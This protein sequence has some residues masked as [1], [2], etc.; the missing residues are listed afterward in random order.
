MS[1][2]DDEEGDLPSEELNMEALDPKVPLPLVP[3]IQVELT[4]LGRIFG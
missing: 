4:F 2:E 3:N 1:A